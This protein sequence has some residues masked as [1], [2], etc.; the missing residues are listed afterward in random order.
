MTLAILVALAFAVGVPGSPLRSAGW[1]MAVSVLVGALV[2]TSARRPAAIWLGLAGVS[3]IPWLA[4]RMSPWLTSLNLLAASG[5]LLASLGLPAAGSLRVTVAHHLARLCRAVG[6]L[7]FGPSHLAHD[8]RR[9]SAARETHGLRHLLPSILVGLGTL[10]VAMFILATGDALLASFFEFGD[11]AGSVA[12]RCF[13]A[14][15]GVAVFAILL[16]AIHV[17]GSNDSAPRTRSAPAVPTLFAIG[18]LAI[19]I[20]TYAAAQISAAILGAEYVEERTGLTYAEY[21]RGGFFQM[22]VIALV[23]VALIGVAR[24]VQHT[25]PEAVRRIRIGAA[26]LTVGVIV[27]VVS[28]VVKLI[29]YADTFGLTMLRVYTVVFACWVGLVAIL[30]FAALL[31][32]AASWFAPVLLGSMCVG[33]FA[34]NI[35]D[36]ERI[37]VA[38]NLDRAESTGKLDVEYLSSLS[39]DAAPTVFARLDSIDAVYERRTRDGYTTVDARDEMQRIWC[40]KIADADSGGGLAYNLARTNA[41][42]A[43]S[44]HCD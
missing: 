10:T 38:H 26:V 1:A 19:A 11:L 32:P 13:V 9:A 5:L 34:M 15:A 41:L 43:A 27:T 21:A 16:G 40:A 17:P 29:V 4:L 7:P 14:L 35:A 6:G 39:L 28:A 20:G 42:A 12:T 31:R 23:S 30:A 33:A 2:A 25:S 36:P 22:V 3:F 8:A 24:G 44:A 37:V 18:G